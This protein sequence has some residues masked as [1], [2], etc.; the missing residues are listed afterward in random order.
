MSFQ[1]LMFSDA[2]VDFSHKEWECLDLEQRHLYRDV[3][4]ENYSNLVSLDIQSRC[5]TKKLS[6]KN[7]IFDREVSQWEIMEICKKHTPECLCF[8]GDWQSK[9]QFERQQ[10]NQEECLK[11]VI[12]NCKKKSRF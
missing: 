6:P 10:E 2:A 12:L 8:R 9:G 7:G 5:Q 3:I 4:L 1:Q 11:Q